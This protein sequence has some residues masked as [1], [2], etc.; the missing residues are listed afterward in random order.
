VTDIHISHTLYLHCG[1][2]GAVPM[3]GGRSRAG[4]K[5]VYHYLS[6]KIPQ[7][8][9]ASLARAEV[10][11]WDP[12][13]SSREDEGVTIDGGHL[14]FVRQLESGIL[15]VRDYSLVSEGVR[16]RYDAERQVT[17]P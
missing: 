17:G 8:I 15:A 3:R 11:G 1:L 13:G 2:R 4:K 6:L 5:S 10:W 14:H 12:H 16:P 9:E 7:T